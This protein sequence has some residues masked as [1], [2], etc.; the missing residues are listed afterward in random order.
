[1]YP[2]IKHIGLELTTGSSIFLEHGRANRTSHRLPQIR[3]THKIHSIFPW[4]QTEYI[5]A[6]AGVRM[7]WEVAL[8]FG[9][10]LTSL[11]AGRRLSPLMYG[12][13]TSK[14]V[15]NLLLAL[16]LFYMI[17]CWITG[18]YSVISGTTYEAESGA[19]S[20]GVV[21][22]TDS[23]FAGGKGVGYLGKG[24]SVTINNVQGNGQ[25]QWVSLYIAN[26]DSSFRNTTIRCVYLSHKFQRSELQKQCQRRF[27][28]CSRSTK[29]WFRTNYSERSRFLEFAE[30]EQLRYF[31]CEP[32]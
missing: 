21:I 32:K 15:S 18:T 30:W 6:I 20:G 8:I 4:G 17:H 2:L 27:A 19:L 24:G 12:P 23:N 11:P 3:I 5:W 13:R 14:Q 25:G 1:M 16:C 29:H 9:I 10:L 31:L 7:Y 28:D 22:H 26:G